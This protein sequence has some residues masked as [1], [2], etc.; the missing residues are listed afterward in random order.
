[1][2]S[3]RLPDNERK[4][5]T[6]PHVLQRVTLKLNFKCKQLARES[7]CFKDAPPLLGRFRPVQNC[8]EYGNLIYLFVVVQFPFC[9]VSDSREAVEFQVSDPSPSESARRLVR[10]LLTVEPMKRLRSLRT[11]K[12]HAFY[13]HF[14]F[15]ALGSKMVTALI[16]MEYSR[17]P[18]IC[19]CCFIV[20]FK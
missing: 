17:P 2:G 4:R 7:E 15:E 11:L 20:F 13:H 8:I 9:N 3:C 19:C 6:R 14:D 18:T 12:N 16:A 5:G 10:A 1:M